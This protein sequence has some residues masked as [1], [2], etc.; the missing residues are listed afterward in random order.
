MSVLQA[1]NAKFPVARV[2]QWSE[3]R[4]KDLVIPTSPFRISLWGVGAGPSDET[5]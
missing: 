1:S 3:R 2:A 5:I 4:H